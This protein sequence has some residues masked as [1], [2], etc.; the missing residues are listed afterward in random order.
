MMQY[1]RYRSDSVCARSGFSLIEIIVGIT[2]LLTLV[3]LMMVQGSR[4]LESGKSMQC[5]TNLRTIGG[6]L[7]QAVLEKNQGGV[8]YAWYSGAGGGG[9]FWNTMLVKDKYLT[10]AELEQLSCPGI[11]YLDENGSHNGR[12]YG[13]EMSNTTD[14][15]RDTR[16]ASG[17][18]EGRA[19]RV[20][21]LGQEF[22]ER[23]IL[24]ADS[25]TSAGDPTIRIFRSD[26]TSFTSGGFHA[27]HENHV[28]AFFYDGHVER[29]DRRR[30]YEL[31]IRR[32]YDAKVN[33]VTLSA[34]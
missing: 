4:Y 1:E 15:L 10:Y 17:G 9:E 22:P 32:I 16:N 13:I 12:H 19:Y 31:G 34:F 24:L 33:P 3:A 28:H 30:L 6:V 29:M 7:M 14:N 27:R 5:V 2:I 8:F 21:L 25:V 11:P 20:S 23:N 18:L 26:S